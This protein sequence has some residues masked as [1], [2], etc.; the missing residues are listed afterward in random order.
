MASQFSSSKFVEAPT[1][2]LLVKSGLVA[3]ALDFTLRRDAFPVFSFE[4]APIELKELR[5][6][7][8][9]DIVVLNS[10][11]RRLGHKGDHRC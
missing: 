1:V 6:N 4:G 7:V 2:T 5:E 3:V 9:A 10:A 11:R 8:I